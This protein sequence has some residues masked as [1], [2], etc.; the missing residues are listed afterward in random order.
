MSS[1]DLGSRVVL[2]GEVESPVMTCISP[3]FM[4]AQGAAP[5]IV[6]WVC[7]W[8]NALYTAHGSDMIL[9]GKQWN[10]IQVQLECLELADEKIQ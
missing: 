4:Q 5:T 9:T 2:K 6:G 8:F 7:G 10:Q 3:L 1:I